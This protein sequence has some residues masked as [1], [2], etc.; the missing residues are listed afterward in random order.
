MLIRWNGE[1]A[2]MSP[3]R[4]QDWLLADKS[5]LIPHV[6]DVQLTDVCAVIQ[7]LHGHT[8]NWNPAAQG[9]FSLNIS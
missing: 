9:S 8:R 1:K 2:G 5:Y 4:K 7:Y 6:L 3:A